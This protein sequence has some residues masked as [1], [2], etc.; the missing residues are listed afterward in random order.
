MDAPIISGIYRVIHEGADPKAVTVEVNFS[1]CWHAFVPYGS[2]IANQLHS[3][4]V[5]LQ[6]RCQD[7]TASLGL[8]HLESSENVVQNNHVLCMIQLAH[9]GCRSCRGSCALRLMMRLR[10]PPLFAAE[11]VVERRRRVHFETTVE[12]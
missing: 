10:L 3:A 11:H 8:H 6:H 2:Q 5:F 4:T 9:G 1:T 12:V 7:S